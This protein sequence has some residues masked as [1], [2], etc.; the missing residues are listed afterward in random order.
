MKAQFRVLFKF[1]LVT[2]LI[3]SPVACQNSANGSNKKSITQEIST[4]SDT[5]VDEVINYYHKLKREKSDV[6]NFEDESELN[7]LGYTYLNSGKIKDAIEIFKLLVTEFPNSSNPYDSL[8]EAYY[9]DGNEKLALKNYERSLALDPKNINAEDWINR[10]KY[11]EYDSSRFSK[12]YSVR[13]YKEDLDQLGKRLT[14]VNPNAYKFISKEDF[15]K[16]IEDKKSLITERTTFSEFIWHCSAIVANIS[17]SHTSLGNFSQERKMI[18]AGLRFPLEVVLIND[19]LYVSQVLNNTGRVKI[20]DEIEAI[21]GIPFKTIQ[22]EAYKHIISQG[23]IETSKKNFFNSHATSI[24]PYSLGFPESYEV[25]L[26]GKSTP[27]ELRMLEQYGDGFK[28]SSKNPCPEF[29]CVSYSEDQKLAVMTIRTFSYYGN[30]FGEF[31]SFVDQSFAAFTEK[32]NRPFNIR[33]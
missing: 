1:F 6:Y 27:V 8:A 14:E 2:S 19:K 4:L 7:K 5:T 9:L 18:P 15:W 10:I 24:I 33:C 11:A 17:C 12:I 25:L 29:L 31:K 32:G 21:N 30:R 23:N 22:Q 3:A 28:R 13:E 16:A 26:K 20:K